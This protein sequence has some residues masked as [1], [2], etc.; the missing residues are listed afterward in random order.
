MLSNKNSLGLE[1]IAMRMKY[2]FGIDIG[3]TN[4]KHGL[5]TGEGELLEKWE[6]PTRLKDDGKYILDDISETIT[7]KIEDLCIDIKDVIG[8][9]LGVPGPVGEDGTVY[10]CVNT[11]WGVFNV[12]DELQQKI[13]IKVKA[14]NDANIAT[15][16]EMWKGGGIGF[17]NIVMITIG[18]GIGGGVVVG[19]RILPGNKGVVGEIGHMQVKEDETRKCSCGRFGCLQQYASAKGI[20]SLADDILQENKNNSVLR[21]VS[22]LDAKIIYDAA[23]SGDKLAGEIIDEAS[24][25]LGK[26]L[27]QT[28]CI[29]TPEMF[30]IGGGMSNAGDVLV[31]LAEKH[32]NTYAFHASKGVK[33][34]LAKL[35]NDAGIYGAAKLFIR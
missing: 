27:A 10:K 32:Y 17:K 24:Q 1:R 6:S 15:L 8:V 30:V 9:G 33:F 25:L 16:G 29:L 12:E 19:G 20:V 23:K 7:Q 11:G 4:I 14:E 28:A 35:G 18:T 26:A 31:E 21:N 3:G 22:N 13:G 2:I 34:A 5:F